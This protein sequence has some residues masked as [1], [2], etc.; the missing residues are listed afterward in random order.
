MPAITLLSDSCH[1][2]GDLLGGRGQVGEPVNFHSGVDWLRENGIEVIDLG[3]K[4]CVE[5]LAD[6]IAAHAEV[7][8]EDIGEE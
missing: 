1:E 7:W 5:L 6:Y 3:S 8:N 4:E 2:K